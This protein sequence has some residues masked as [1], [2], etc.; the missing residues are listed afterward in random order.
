MTTADTTPP[1]RKP[2]DSGPRQLRVGLILRRRSV[3]V[4]S[5][6][7]AP[8]TPPRRLAAGH[9]WLT[10][11]TRGDEIVHLARVPDP[12]VQRS[13]RRDVTGPHHFGEA[14]EGYVVVALPFD[15]LTDLTR[16]QIHALPVEPRAGVAD[17]DLSDELRGRVARKDRVRTVDFA[18]VAASPDWAVVGPMI[19]APVDPGRFEVYRDRAGQWRWRLR[20][21]GGGIVASSND[22]FATRAEA[23][24]EVTWIRRHSADSP[25]T[26]LD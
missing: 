7:V 9:P 5:L 1:P 20:Q 16:S 2:L 12:F 6:A 18:Q 22:S 3:T 4:A 8:G 21:T 11:V 25:T 15:S 24:A 14:D 19:G 26:S 13:V 17:A 10:G 23:E